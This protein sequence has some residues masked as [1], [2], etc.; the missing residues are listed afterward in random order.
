MLV[1]GQKSH[2]GASSGEQKRH[3]KLPPRLAK[4]REQ[5]EKG[6]QHTKPVAEPPARPSSVVV[7][8]V[9]PRLLPAVEPLMQLRETGNGFMP[10][11]ENWDNEMANNIPATST[12]ATPTSVEV[13]GPRSECPFNQ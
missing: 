2:S 4:Q 1:Q 11:I 6:K 12:S 3:S 7:T 9:Q 8:S 5:K 10:N 13:Q